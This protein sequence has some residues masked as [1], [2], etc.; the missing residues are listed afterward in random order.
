MPNVLPIVKIG[1]PIL[2]EEAHE[3]E[4]VDDP[5]IQKLIDDMIETYQN[6]HGLGIA[7]PQVNEDRRIF[8]ISSKPCPLYPDAPTRE[9][10]AMI[11]PVILRRSKRKVTDWESCLSIPDTYGLVPRHATV[12]MAFTN[13]Q[14][15]RVRETFRGFLARVCQHEQ[16][17]LDGILFLERL[18]PP[19]TFTR[20]EYEQNVACA[21][22]KMHA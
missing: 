3:V 7:G 22:H 14:G 11:N 18:N 15:K 16:D 20:E 19:R 4:A 9:P 1:H 13:R 12:T 21:R 10:T 5:V 6:A 2:T 8:I 17:H